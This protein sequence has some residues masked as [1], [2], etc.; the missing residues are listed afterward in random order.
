MKEKYQIILALFLITGILGYS[1]PIPSFPKEFLQWIQ[2][3]TMYYLMFMPEVSHHLNLLQIYVCEH[4]ASSYIA[5]PCPSQFSLSFSLAMNFWY[6]LFHIY[7][8]CFLGKHIWI[9]IWVRWPQFLQGCLLNALLRCRPHSN[10]FQENP[11][12]DKVS[13]I[14]SCYTLRG[15][16]TKSVFLCA[17]HIYENGTVWFF[18]S[19]SS[20]QNS[21]RPPLQNSGWECTLIS[22]TLLIGSKPLVPF[23]T[24]HWFKK[25]WMQLSCH[26][27]SLLALHANTHEHVCCEIRQIGWQS[28]RWIVFL[29]DLERSKQGRI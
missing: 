29:L 1:H 8:S 21:D 23:D 7:F 28:L 20:C 4:N 26:R 12:V 19:T 2:W 18:F 25:R 22:H 6:I 24:T 15:L 9:I 3:N 17:L 10:I 13:F 16:G 14:C 5:C 11:P 27:R